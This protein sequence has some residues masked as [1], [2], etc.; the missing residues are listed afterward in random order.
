MQPVKRYYYR[1]S[2][3][4]GGSST[5]RTLICPTVGEVI[6]KA[7]SQYKETWKK[8]PDM[9]IIKRQAEYTYN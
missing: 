7:F 1:V 6:D 2:S 9:V 4:E 3:R 5:S 8:W